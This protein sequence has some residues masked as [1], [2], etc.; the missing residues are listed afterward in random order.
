MIGL[1]A[2]QPEVYTDTETVEK[3]M[4]YLARYGLTPEVPVMRPLNL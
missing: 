1:D 3:I 2:H 4:E